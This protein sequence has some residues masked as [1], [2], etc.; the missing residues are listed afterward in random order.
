MV[1]PWG[2]EGTLRHCPLPWTSHPITQAQGLHFRGQAGEQQVDDGLAQTHPLLIV[3]MKGPGV[4]GTATPCP[5]HV[6]IPQ[7]LLMA[8]TKGER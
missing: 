1:V 6:L 5:M 4:V 8:L 2:T 3:I 7:A